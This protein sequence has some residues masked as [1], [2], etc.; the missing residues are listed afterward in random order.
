MKPNT[1]VN[2]YV[3]SNLA[4][5][6]ILCLIAVKLICYFVTAWIFR[7]ILSI[8]AV[9]GLLYFEERIFSRVVCRIVD[10]FLHGKS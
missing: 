5:W 9:I 4:A 6:I 8:A 10:F 1:E 7:G 3:F 2:I